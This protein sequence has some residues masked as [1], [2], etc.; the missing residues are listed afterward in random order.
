MKV[1]NTLQ[2]CIIVRDVV[3]GSRA[4]GN[5]SVVWYLISFSLKTQKFHFTFS[6]AYIWTNIGPVRKEIALHSVWD[7]NERIAILRDL[8]SSTSTPIQKSPD[9]GHYCHCLQCR[10]H[11]SLLAYS[12]L[13]YYLNLWAKFITQSLNS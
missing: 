2:K 3:N 9:K 6:N 7:C 13:V 10:W 5:S 8:N 1:D 4:R 11:R 12:F